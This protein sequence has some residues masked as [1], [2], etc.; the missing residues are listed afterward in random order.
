MI[1]LGISVYTHYHG[2]SFF[3]DSK[4]SGLMTPSAMSVF[5]GLAM[6]IVAIFGFFGSLKLSTCMV[7]VVCIFVRTNVFTLIKRPFLEKVGIR[8]QH[9]HD[10]I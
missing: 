5:I 3:Y 7:N 4:L 10:N 1:V 2:F 8:T 9:T 6:L